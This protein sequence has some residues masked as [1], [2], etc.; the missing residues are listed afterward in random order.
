M[1]EFTVRNRLCEYLAF[2]REEVFSDTELRELTG[3]KKTL[4]GVFLTM[5][6]TV[7]FV[8]KSIRT[9]KCHFIINESNIKRRAKGKTGEVL[10]SEVK[11]VYKSRRGFFVELK[12]DGGMPIPFRVLTY[13]QVASMELLSGN[14][15]RERSNG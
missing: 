7:M 4:A 9:G 11:A 3:F 6:A 14:L 15:L 2:V 12:S 1:I 8:V 10:W 13:E 5:F